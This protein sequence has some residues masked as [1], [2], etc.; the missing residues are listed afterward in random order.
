MFTHQQQLLKII[1]IFMNGIESEKKKRET[2]K[3]VKSHSSR[4][5]SFILEIYDHFYGFFFTALQCAAES[6]WEF[7]ANKQIIFN[8]EFEP[9]FFTFCAAGSFFFIR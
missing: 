3:L 7:S 9:F 5:I 4:D 6:E 1:L 8:T 2:E